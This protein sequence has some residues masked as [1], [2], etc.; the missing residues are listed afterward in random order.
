MQALQIR[1][2]SVPLSHQFSRLNT[3]THANIHTGKQTQTPSRCHVML[4]LPATQVPSVFHTPRVCP[5]EEKLLCK[6][7]PVALFG[8]LFLNSKGMNLWSASYKHKFISPPQPLLVSHT[9]FPL[10]PCNGLQPE[11]RSCATKVMLSSPGS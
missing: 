10:F 3:C 9:F 5:P 7:E 4:V 1:K 8:M 2:L 6:G 11:A